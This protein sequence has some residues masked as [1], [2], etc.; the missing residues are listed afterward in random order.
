MRTCLLLLGLML[1]FYVTCLVFVFGVLGV[2]ATWALGKRAFGT[3]APTC[4]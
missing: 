1:G 3:P 4:P 2:G